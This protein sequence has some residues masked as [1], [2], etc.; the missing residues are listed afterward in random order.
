MENLDSKKYLEDLEVQNMVSS[1]KQKV[2]DLKRESGWRD[3]WE[4]RLEKRRREIEE[5]NRRN[6]EMYGAN[7]NDDMKT[8]MGNNPF[9]QGPRS[10]A[11]S[12]THES[13]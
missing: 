13:I 7:D 2:A 6:K 10:V 11:S 9:E 1:L 5:E 4:E 8:N 12:K 3:K